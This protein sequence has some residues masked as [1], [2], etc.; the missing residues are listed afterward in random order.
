[1]RIINKK[2]YNRLQLGYGAKK[3]L[4][5]DLGDGAKQRIYCISDDKD[6]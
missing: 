2:E 4:R 6:V 5:E 3:I 1:M